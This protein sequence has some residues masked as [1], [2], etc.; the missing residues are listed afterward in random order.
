MLP[1][2]AAALFGAAIAAPAG[3]GCAAPP[4]PSSSCEKDALKMESWDFLNVNYNYKIDQMTPSHGFA[5]AI[6]TFDLVNPITKKTV[7][8]KG[9][10]VPTATFDAPFTR[11]DDRFTCTA[12]DGT[13]DK[14]TTFK[15]QAPYWGKYKTGEQFSITVEQNFRCPGADPSEYFKATGALT[16][17]SEFTSTC[18]SKDMPN[19]SYTSDSKTSYDIKTEV[20][21]P[22]SD[23][24][25]TTSVVGIA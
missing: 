2:V 16:L 10:G 1:I 25:K 23:K 6:V 22:Y 14:D 12:A 17:P 24:I 19:E 21:G 11:P 3:P 15:F 18:V 7:S 4:P 9:D 5:E 8:C 20:C 13:V